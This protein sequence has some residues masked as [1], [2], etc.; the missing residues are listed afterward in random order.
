MTVPDLMRCGV[1]LL[2][3]LACDSAVAEESR[4]DV[5]PLVISAALDED[6]FTPLLD[7][8]QAAYPLIEVDFREG[9][10]LEVDNSVSADS[11]APDVVISSAM[12]LQMARVNDGWA[13][14]I[15]SPQARMWPDWAKWR[16]EVFGFTF[17]PIVMAYRLDLARHM[18]PPQKH[19]DLHR[20]LTSHAD[21]LRGRVTT[22][23]PQ[24][25]AI[26]YALAQQD[27][28]YSTRF[29]ELVAAM[30][31][32][33]ASLENDTR[34]MLE[35][36]EEGRYW[37]GYNLIG[38]Y[39]MAYAQHHPDVIVQVPMDYSLVMMRMAFVH[40][41]AEHPEAAETFVNFLL[42]QDGQ[43]V[44]AG[45][46]PLFSPL[47]DMA[48]P[49]TAKRL[50]DQVGEHLYPIPLDATLLAFVDPARREVFMRQWQETFVLPE[51][52]SEATP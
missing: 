11:P 45:Q 32:L 4:S 26:G 22:Y 19:A 10:T 17:E 1:L 16:N 9:S 44:L 8:F 13:R 21:L 29:W 30:G 42:S 39:A 12:P 31:Q 14:R 36:I 50:R 51:Q 33:D 6:V 40:R 20:L 37:L 23:T 41:D 43:H 38:S 49:W 24:A 48:G 46:T 47:T 25:S 2:V 7:A 18:L 15:D 52:T 28:R 3:A 27:A 5:T 34:S 35:G